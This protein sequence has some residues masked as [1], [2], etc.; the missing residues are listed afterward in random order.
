V[1]SKKLTLS[2]LL[3]EATMQAFPLLKQ[4]CRVS[5]LVLCYCTVTGCSS[6]DDLNFKNDLD[7]PVIVKTHRSVTEKTCAIETVGKVSAHTTLL[8]KSYGGLYIGEYWVEDE[9]G[10]LIEKLS[11][12]GKNITKKSVGCA[13]KTVWNIILAPKPSTPPAVVS[14]SLKAK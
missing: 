4:I 13:G 3:K 11:P 12:T 8:Y 7:F 10:T 5:I 9:Q 1:D 2:R 6:T 14:V